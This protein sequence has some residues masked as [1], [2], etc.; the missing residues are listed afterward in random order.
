MPLILI[1]SP[2]LLCYK[3][4]SKKED[5]NMTTDTFTISYNTMSNERI[6]YE[7]KA[8]GKLILK[9]I[10]MIVGKIQFLVVNALVYLKK[11]RTSS[12]KFAGSCFRR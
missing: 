3:M 10:C 7:R 12:S 11:Q 5:K 8:A 2:Q 6:Q 4:K 1:M 9:H